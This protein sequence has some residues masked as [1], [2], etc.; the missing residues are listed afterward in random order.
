VAE[1]AGAVAVAAAL[2]GRLERGPEPLVL[3]V[4]GRNVALPRLAQVL[5][6]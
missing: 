3:V 6:G 2:I 4:T 1:G 5:G